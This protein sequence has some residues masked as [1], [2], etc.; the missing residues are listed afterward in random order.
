MYPARAA[1]ASPQPIITKPAPRSV[2]STRTS[3]SPACP[4]RLSL[5]DFDGPSARDPHATHHRHPLIHHIPDQSPH[6]KE[7]RSFQKANLLHQE[8]LVPSFLTPPQPKAPRKGSPSHFPL[9]SELPFD[10]SSPT[11]RPDISLSSPTSA[12]QSS[13]VTSASPSTLHSRSF[14][15]LLQTEQPL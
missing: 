6:P 12:S 13:T 11:L 2:L 10:T 7:V 14:S 9:T 15:S 3:S 1:Q 4:A 8:V 5:P